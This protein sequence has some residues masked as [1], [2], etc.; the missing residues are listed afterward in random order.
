MSDSQAVFPF[1]SAERP[2]KGMTWSARPWNVI[3]GTTRPGLQP[4]IGFVS[5][6]SAGETGAKAAIKD[7]VEGV[8]A[9]KFVCACRDDYTVA[10]LKAQETLTKPPP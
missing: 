4:S 10:I 7:A 2:S 3:M 8:Q 5:G 6:Y 1:L 9:S